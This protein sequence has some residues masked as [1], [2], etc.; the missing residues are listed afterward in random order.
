[1]TIFAYFVCK[2][3]ISQV[4]FSE[5]PSITE[6]LGANREEFL[7]IHANEPNDVYALQNV[8]DLHPLAIDA[9]IHRH[10]PSK[11]EDYDVYVF[12]IIDGVRHR[13]RA[14]GIIEENSTGKE[15][16]TDGELDEDDLYIFLE[17]RWIITINF[18]CKEFQTNLKQ[19]I[20][21]RLKSSHLYLLPS[22]EL[23]S[24]RSPSNTQNNDLIDYTVDQITTSE[25]AYTL[26]IEEILAGY[27]KIIG[28]L[29]NRVDLL[30]ETVY[31]KYTKTQLFEILSVRR[32]L[33][34]LE[35][36]LE[37]LIRALVDIVNEIVQKRLDKDSKK[38]IRAIYSRV[39]YLENRVDHM[40]QRIMALLEAHNSASGTSLNTTMKT[41]TIITT[42]AIPFTV[43]SGIAGMNYRHMPFLDDQFG[44]YYALASM[45]AG[46]VG[47]LGFFK[48]KKWI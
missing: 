30:E 4:N 3:N 20:S 38:H 36:T 23:L 5:V 28:E 40:R 24:Q 26:A 39:V 46:A 42:I 19:R 11:I 15:G 10:Q 14:D 43:I 18:Y 34:F 12:A 35:G 29:V 32:N 47:L 27:Y 45:M 1:L 31:Q 9:I 37:M 16:Y 17:S 2:E 13:E 21:R 8:F 7:W 6:G 25:M 44:L 48:V 33:G 41:L 22:K